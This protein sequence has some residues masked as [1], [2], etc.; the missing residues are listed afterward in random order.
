MNK[1]SYIMHLL[2]DVNL[3]EEIKNKFVDVIY[4][5]HK[6]FKIVY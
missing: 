1:D 4:I 3:S 5:E 6:Y 2:K